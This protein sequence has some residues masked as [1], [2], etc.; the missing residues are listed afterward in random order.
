M[1]YNMEETGFQA[2]LFN[3]IVSQVYNILKEK[4]VDIGEN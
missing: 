4:D 2:P 3:F 1:S